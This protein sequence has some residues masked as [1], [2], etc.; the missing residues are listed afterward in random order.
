MPLA[1]SPL[2]RRALAHR[3]NVPLHCYHL[4]IGGKV[5]PQPTQP[6]FGCWLHTN[7]RHHRAKPK[8]DPPTTCH[9]DQLHPAQSLRLIGLIGATLYSPMVFGGCGLSTLNGCDGRRGAKTRTGSSA[10]T[11][12]LFGGVPEH[13]GSCAYGSPPENTPACSGARCHPCLLG[14]AL[15]TISRS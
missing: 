6:P 4:E 15:P 3:S 12:P 1:C 8:E 2:R 14:R 11:P 7:T 5:A 9:M 10:G 13:S